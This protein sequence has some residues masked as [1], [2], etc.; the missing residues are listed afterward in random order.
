MLWCPPEVVFVCTRILPTSRT[1]HL[2]QGPAKNRISPM[3]DQTLQSITEPCG[4][5]TASIATCISL[6]PQR[7]K[8]L[9]Q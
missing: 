2:N 1:A 5:K 4:A 8:A 7:R 3:E 6:P 9:R